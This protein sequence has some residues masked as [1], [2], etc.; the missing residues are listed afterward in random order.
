MD[1]HTAKLIHATGPDHCLSRPFRF[2]LAGAG[3]SGGAGTMVSST[4]S[5]GRAEHILEELGHTLFA[6]C[7]RKERDPFSL[8]TLI[9]ETSMS[10]GGLDANAM[11]GC[12]TFDDCRDG[13][14]FFLQLIKRYRLH[15]DEFRDRI[16]NAADPA[17]RARRR[18]QY[19]WL[20]QHWYRGAEFKLGPGADPIVGMTRGLLCLPGECAIAAPPPPPP[21][22]P[23]TREEGLRDCDLA[24]RA[25]LAEGRLPRD[26]ARERRDCRAECTQITLRRP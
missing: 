18:A 13:E 24:H 15:G 16:N 23:P 10:A 3:G 20:K 11:P 5:G 17:E 1:K 2:V 7:L 22:P 4:R 12:N 14:H 25:C 19:A 21:P 9:Y 6:N 26:C 8:F